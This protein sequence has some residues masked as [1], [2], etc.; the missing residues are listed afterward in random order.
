MSIVAQNNTLNVQI[1][2]RKSYF[3]M[4]PDLPTLSLRLSLPNKVTFYGMPS[5]STPT[6]Y[7][8]IFHLFAAK[9]ITSF[10]FLSV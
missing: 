10:S 2:T 8:P 9:I 6:I 5:S 1:D 7:L 3:L 4:S